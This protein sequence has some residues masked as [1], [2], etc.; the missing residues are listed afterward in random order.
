MDH[1][2]FLGS[3]VGGKSVINYSYTDMPL[4]LLMWD[5]RYFLVF[6]WALPWILWPIRPAEGGHFNE[7]APTRSNIWCIFMHGVLILIQLAFIV[8]LP[9]ALMFPFGMVLAGW[10]AF[11]TLNWLL[12]KTLNGNTIVYESDPKYAPALPE[13][14]HEQWVFI[15]G[16]A[17]G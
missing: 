9:L 3:Q 15:N 7:L 1:T 13:H 10:T 11:F 17:A 12:C 6:A 2:L 8:T 16:V 4:K 14:E 5:M